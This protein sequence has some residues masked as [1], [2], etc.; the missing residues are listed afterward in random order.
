MARTAP[1]LPPETCNVKMH[2][3]LYNLGWILFFVFVAFISGLSAATVVV[4]W[5]APPVITEQITHTGYNTEKNQF[6]APDPVMIK[7]TKQRLLVIY[8][9]RKKVENQY[10]TEDALVTEAGLISSDGWAVASVS[11]FSLGQEKNWEAVDYQGTVYKVNAV[12]YDT[13]SDLVYF[14]VTGNGF[15]IMSFASSQELTAGIGVWVASNEKWSSNMVGDFTL[16]STNGKKNYLIWKPQYAHS[17]LQEVIVG[18]LLFDNNGDLLG[19][20]GDKELVIPADLIRQQV[21]SILGNRAIVYKGLNLDGYFITRIFKDN[22]WQE[23][24]GFY[25][26]SAYKASTSTVGRGDV[27]LEVNHEPIAEFNLA[28]Q[29]FSAPDQ[30]SLTVWRDNQEVEIK[31]SKTVVQG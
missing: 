8:D 19:L 16:L 30:F 29:L 10:Y 7:Q 17:L 9:K 24:K 22:S 28:E 14:K 5:L 3:K 15:R 4:A 13:L 18:S 31:V 2:N 11:G 23:E 12:V 21:D 25:V 6:G 20:V 26:D 1:H 27:I